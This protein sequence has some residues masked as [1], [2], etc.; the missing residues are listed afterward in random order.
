[1]W[2]RC[3]RLYIFKTKEAEAKIHKLSL[4]LLSKSSLVAHVISRDHG[5]SC[6][7]GH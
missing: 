4:F 7:L 3:G 2:Y 6:D 1:M 5:V